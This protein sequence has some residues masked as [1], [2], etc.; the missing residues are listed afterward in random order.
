MRLR[1]VLNDESGQLMRSV[2]VYGIAFVIVILLIQL[3]LVNG[4]IKVSIQFTYLGISRL[5]GLA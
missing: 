4:L 3:P 2:F 5:V 1:R